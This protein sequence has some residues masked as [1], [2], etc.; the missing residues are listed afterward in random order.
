MGAMFPHVPLHHVSVSCPDS[1]A[2]EGE[3]VVEEVFAQDAS[4]NCG[5]GEPS[6]VRFN[7]AI[8]LVNEWAWLQR[9]A[10]AM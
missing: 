7:V 4:R 6:H 1:V 9:N 5:E 10:F 3:L 8:V 2:S